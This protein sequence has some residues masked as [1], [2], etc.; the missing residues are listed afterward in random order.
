M[1]SRQHKSD[2][3][4]VMPHQAA[5]FRHLNEFGELITAIAQPLSVNRPT[6]YSVLAG[7]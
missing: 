5:V 1:P 4:S 6:V 2:R 7:S 3:K